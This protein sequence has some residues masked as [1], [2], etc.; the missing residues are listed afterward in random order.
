MYLLGG[1]R[2]KRLD[3][4]LKRWVADEKEN[5]DKEMYKDISDVR[6]LVLS[7]LGLYNRLMRR[8]FVRV[9]DKEE[10]FEKM[11]LAVKTFN[12]VVTY[13]LTPPESNEDVPFSVMY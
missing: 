10:L 6:E 13:Y 1:R 3:K 12:S 8:E 4:R 9:T 7:A 5:K 11:E 2:L